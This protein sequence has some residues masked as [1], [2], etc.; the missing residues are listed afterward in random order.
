M[1]ASKALARASLFVFAL[2]AMPAMADN[3]GYQ[4]TEDSV[5]GFLGSVNNLLTIAS[6]AVVTIAVIFAGYQIAF[7][8]KRIGDVAPILIGGLLIGAAGQIAAMIM[9]KNT[10]QG[11]CMTEGST[12]GLIVAHLP[13]LF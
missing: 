13:N 5:C 8:H 7:A 9:P 3:S 6:I 2:I 10:N 4:E 1:V 12:V 11:A